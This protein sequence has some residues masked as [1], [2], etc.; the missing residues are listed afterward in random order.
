MSYA[1]LIDTINKLSHE[2]AFVCPQCG[3]P[4]VAG[5][6]S[7]YADCAQCST[8]VKLRGYSAVGG[9][10]EDVVDAV[11]RWMGSGATMDAAMKRK[12]EI[13]LDSDAERDAD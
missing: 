6:L 10:V 9:E 4:G 12:R 5:I 3:R 11:L 13:D 7:M 1:S 8:R 2:R